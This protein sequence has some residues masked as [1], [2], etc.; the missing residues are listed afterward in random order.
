MDTKSTYDSSTESLI[1]E[2]LD[3]RDWTESSVLENLSNTFRNILVLPNKST[4]L[5]NGFLF[6][7][8]D[9]DIVDS[10]NLYIDSIN[11]QKNVLETI[12][13][14][15]DSHNLTKGYELLYQQELPALKIQRELC[16][17]LISSFLEIEEGKDKINLEVITILQ[18][19]L[20]L[21]TH[22]SE[23]IDIQDDQCV[24]FDEDLTK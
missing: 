20:D 17:Y 2:M 24:E 11:A 10:R 6:S 1:P 3:E 19:V 16:K 8:S 12:S 18:R 23:N 22:S 7:I 15:I 9:G 4:P 5:S 13:K 14:S 21:H